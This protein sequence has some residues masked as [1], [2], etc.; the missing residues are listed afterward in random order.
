MTNEIEFA[1]KKQQAHLTELMVKA[2]NDFFYGEMGKD[3]N[4]LIAEY[5]DL[6]LR[7]SQLMY[8]EQ[9][10][11]GPR[12]LID[13]ESGLLFMIRIVG[14]LDSAE[15]IALL[16]TRIEE[17]KKTAKN[18][19]RPVVPSSACDTESGPSKLNPLFNQM[20]ENLS[21]GIRT[22]GKTESE[23]MWTFY[24]HL[25]KILYQIL[26]S[27][28]TD[29]FDFHLL[30]ALTTIKP[31]DWKDSP[32]P[33]P[34]SLSKYTHDLLDCAFSFTGAANVHCLTVERYPSMFDIVDDAIDRLT[35]K[36]T[37]TNENHYTEL[38][39]RMSTLVTIREAVDPDRV[40][41][42]AS[43]SQPGEKKAM[44]SYAVALD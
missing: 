24:Q 28:K 21:A 4:E 3:R 33:K 30:E 35:D 15:E 36:V 29:G 40:L 22:Y 37:Q 43:V 23:A 13:G 17:Q 18:A 10:S 25:D 27:G 5:K 38:H 19:T 9:A 8:K 31:F 34:V 7:I 1:V 39:S 41:G 11:D 2:F 42:K 26:G 32:V 12:V 14:L 6:L 44:K 20:I 16:E